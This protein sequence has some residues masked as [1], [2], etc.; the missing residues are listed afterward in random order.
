MGVEM[1]Q[2][3]ASIAQHVG[4]GGT[5]V[6]GPFK[7]PT[8][9]QRTRLAVFYGEAVRL[10]HFAEVIEDAQGTRVAV[11]FARPMGVPRG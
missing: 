2:P 8:P 7:A 4:A 9:E 3:L 10:G 11:S 5:L 6:L 1:Q